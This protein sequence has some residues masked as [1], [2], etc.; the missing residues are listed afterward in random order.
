[1]VI[2]NTNV[3]PVPYL[4]DDCADMIRWLI[5]RGQLKPLDQAHVYPGGAW[6]SPGY[7]TGGHRDQ[8]STA[9]P[10][11]NAYQRIGAIRTAVVHR[12]HT[13]DT[14]PKGWLMALTDEQQDD[15]YSKV[16]S[17]Y[18]HTVEGPDPKANTPRSEWTWTQRLTDWM[19]RNDQNPPK[20]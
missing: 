18:R 14:P 13:P 16:K 17:I 1:M 2:G 9:C 8:K 20:D 3:D 15:L 4:V 12:P 5:D 7:P 19:R 11:D 10:G 6:S